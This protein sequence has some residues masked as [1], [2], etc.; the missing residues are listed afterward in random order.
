MEARLG[1]LCRTDKRYS[2]EPGGGGEALGFENVRAQE[3]AFL[4]SL[5]KK[6]EDICPLI[7]K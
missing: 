7:R 1:G 4:F 5:L 6:K 3:N 2:E